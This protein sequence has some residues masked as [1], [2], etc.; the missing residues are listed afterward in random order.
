MKIKHKKIIKYISIFAISMILFSCLQFSASY[1]L[2]RDAYYHVK[3]AEMMSEGNF[4]FDSFPWL[5]FTILKDHFVDHHFLFHILLIPFFSMFGVKIAGA[6][7]VSLAMLAFYFILERYKIRFSFLWTMFLLASSC[8][9]LFRMTLIRAPSLSLAFLILILFALFKNKLWLIALLS[10]FYV[11]L[12]GGFFFF[13]IFALF[14][15]FSYF[16]FTKKLAWKSLLICLIFLGLGVIFDPYFLNL[17]SF[18]KIQILGTGPFANISVGAE[19]YPFKEWGLLENTVLA[20]AGFLIGTVVF[21]IDLINKRYKKQ[22]GLFSIKLTL[23]LVSVLFLILTLRSQRFVEYMAPF[24]LL[25]CAFSVNDYLK[26]IKFKILDCFSR[27]WLKSHWI[28]LKLFLVGLIMVFSFGIYNIHHAFQSIKNS[29]IKNVG[30]IKK[31]AEW[32]AVNTKEEE[33]IFNLDWSDFPPLFYYNDKNY[34]CFGLDPA[35]TYNFDKDLYKKWK[36]VSKKEVDIYSVVKNDFGADY[37]VS[38]DKFNTA[39]ESMENDVRF[40]KVFE[41]A[42]SLIYRLK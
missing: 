24:F 41:S 1:F 13:L 16:I 10:F 14:Y 25:F 19:W 5:Q 33:I 28:F 32:L 39:N 27:K 8:S 21:I 17:F 35:F 2:G 4:V 29:S 22:K 7:F 9:F 36:G 31:A 20:L 23:G 15:F 40:K 38:N 11:W 6:L 18:L 26:R 37:I 3:L 30:D 34:Y 42:Y 12:Y